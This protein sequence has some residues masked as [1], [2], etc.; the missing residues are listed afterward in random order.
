MHKPRLA[1]N[2]AASMIQTVVSVLSMLLTYHFMMRWLTIT[3]IGL[4]SLVIGSVT[5]T[6]LS[7]FGLGG[8]VMRFVAIDLA[9]G[10]RKL[11]AKSIGMALTMNLLAVSAVVLIARPFILSY[12]LHLTPPETHDTVRALMQ[13]AV[14]AVILT[15]LSDVLCSSLDGCQRM[16]I[17]AGIQTLGGLTQ[18]VAT[19]IILPRLGA[20]GLG[21]A[22]IAQALVQILCAGIATYVQIGCR[23]RAYA[24][25]EKSR[26][27]EM[28]S[29]GGGMQLN[30]FVQMLFE[31]LVKILLT[32]YSSVA[33]AGYFDMA[34]K[35]LLQFRSLIVAGYRALVP[36]VAAR[37]ASDSQDK[38]AV[39]DTYRQAVG[40]LMFVM[41]PYYAVTAAV[42]P[43][44]LTLWKGHYDVTFLSMAMA[45]NVGFLI[46][47]INPPSYLIFVALGRLRWVI[48]SHLL[49]GLIVALAGPLLGHFAGAAGIMAAAVFGLSLGSIL[50]VAM[51]HHEFHY[52]WAWLLPLRRVPSA[53]LVVAAISAS[54]ILAMQTGTPSLAVMITLPV[55]TGLL[56]LGAAWI[57][58]VRKE[59]WQLVRA[60]LASRKRT[61][62][63]AS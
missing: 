61:P 20:D 8:S 58:P 13:A 50:V 31:P 59:G 25:F 36:H 56:A 26:L 5:I 23:L 54:A 22:Q 35:V 47:T 17:R 10:E 14:I 57:D 63:P 38:T 60:R 44:A 53:L 34:T 45:M 3:Q 15:P 12:L 52:R 41:L 4:W 21:L 51:F 7:D 29:Y 30:G 42:L 27:R 16:D 6:R 46:N 19:L 28:F 37:M 55:M 18:F 1:R 40:P 49:T 24:A 48:G 39:L 62:A 32:S 33:M 43:L 2:A 9:R 11:A